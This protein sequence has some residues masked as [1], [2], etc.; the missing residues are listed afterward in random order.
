[1]NSTLEA[2]QIDL[3][4]SLLVKFE[5]LFLES[6][7]IH[8]LLLAFLSDVAQTQFSRPFVKLS[9]VILIHQSDELSFVDLFILSFGSKVIFNYNEIVCEYLNTNVVQS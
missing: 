3:L 6:L 7:I 4:T 8:T 9:L 2:C 5:D 1:M